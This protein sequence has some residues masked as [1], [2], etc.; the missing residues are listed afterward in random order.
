MSLVLRF[1]G[2]WLY[3]DA[4]YMWISDNIVGRWVTDLYSAESGHVS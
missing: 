3:L 2:I 1:S 4:A